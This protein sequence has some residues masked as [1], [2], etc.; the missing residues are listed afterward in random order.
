[1]GISWVY[2]TVKRLKLFTIKPPIVF[3]PISFAFK[4][5]LNLAVRDLDWRRPKNLGVNLMI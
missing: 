5:H 4:A 3:S 1:M 2:L